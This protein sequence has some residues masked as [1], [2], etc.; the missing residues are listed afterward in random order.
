MDIQDIVLFFVFSAK[1]DLPITKLMKLAFLA[2]V[3]HQRLYGKPVSSM[4][5]TYHNYGPFAQPIYSATDA[6][7]ID[8]LIASTTQRASDRTGCQFSV[9]DERGDGVMPR[10]EEFP[11]RA[12]RALKLT[13][14][15]YGHLS[16]S[17]INEAAYNTE[18]MRAAK[19]GDCLNLKLEKRESLIRDPAVLTALTALKERAP[20]PIIQDKGDPAASAAED[21]ALL[22]ELGTLRREASRE[23]T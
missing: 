21:L 17:Q 6:L 19:P 15:R 12:R 20:A 1:R 7:E 16:V 22:D 3:E 8:G 11:M 23:L 14:Q 18:P 4:E 5:W 13:F 9:V 10:W 2:D